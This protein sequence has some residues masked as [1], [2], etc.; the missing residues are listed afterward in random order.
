MG[1]LLR[2][3]VILLL[4]MMALLLVHP[5]RL[6]RVLVLM[7]EDMMVVDHRGRPGLEATLYE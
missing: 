2:S 1:V 4:L 3:V 5:R 7:G 6:L